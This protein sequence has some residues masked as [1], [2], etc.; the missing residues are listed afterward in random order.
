MGSRPLSLIESSTLPIRPNNLEIQ[1]LLRRLL[2]E[3]SEWAINE[4]VAVSLVERDDRLTVRC[5]EQCLY[6]A[7]ENLVDNAIKFSSKGEISLKA[8][9][10]DTGAPAIDVSDTG[11]GID[12]RDHDKI[13]DSFFQCDMTSKRRYRG[14]GLGLTL[15]RLAS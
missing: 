6:R 10:N 12:E 4:N 5:D 7:I 3:R 13:F 8:Y 11:I 14:A 1:P 9:V 15:A 2:R